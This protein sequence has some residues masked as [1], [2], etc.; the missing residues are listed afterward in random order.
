MEDF[1][2]LELSTEDEVDSETEANT[3]DHKRKVTNLS[4]L[5][6]LV[7]RKSEC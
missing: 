4:I 6:L 2:A 1:G 5:L 3:S 7:S